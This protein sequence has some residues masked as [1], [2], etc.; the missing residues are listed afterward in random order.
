VEKTIALFFIKRMKFHNLYNYYADY[1]GSGSIEPDEINYILD[2]INEVSDFF[3]HKDINFYLTN[4][5]SSVFE[6]ENNIVFLSNESSN[7]L[8]SNNFAL[9]FSNFFRNQQDKRYKQFPLGLNKFINKNLK[10][11]L[12]L[13]PFTERKYDCFFAGF[14]HPSRSEFQNSIYNLICDKNFFHFASGNNLQTFENNLNPVQYSETA[15]DS[16][17]M[18][19]PAGGI[20]STSYRY[21]ESV[22]YKN[23]PIYIEREN[24]KMFFEE[25]NP[26]SVCLKSWKDLSQNVIDDAI[27]NFL[28][29]EKDFEDFFQNKMSKKA[30]CSYIINEIKQSLLI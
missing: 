24:Q 6:T 5:P 22:Y 23:I 10:S 21:F 16:K 29:K 27:G 8:N 28:Q 9:C 19:C 17:V 26:I 11:G 30:I 12:N 18:L 7:R 15:S 14:I 4:D 20:H 3:F 2:I 1:L 25:C 13:K